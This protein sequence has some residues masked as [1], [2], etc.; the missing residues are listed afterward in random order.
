MEAKAEAKPEVTEKPFYTQTVKVPEHLLKT[1]DTLSKQL[2][3]KAYRLM[4]DRS[5]NTLNFKAVDVAHVSL[6]EVFIPLKLLEGWA[7]EQG[8]VLYISEDSMGDVL[9]L[10]G[11]GKTLLFHATRPENSKTMVNTKVSAANFN[12]S[13][14]HYSN[15]EEPTTPKVPKLTFP[16]EFSIATATLQKA[17]KFLL[18]TSDHMSFIAENN[19]VRLSTI[20]KKKTVEGEFFLGTVTM[21]K[22]FTTI[23]SAYPGN[24]L[25]DVVQSFDPAIFSSV[26]IGINNDLPMQVVG[27]SQDGIVLRRLLAPRIVDD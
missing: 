10:P 6:A 1:L 18:K 5:T 27:V 24:Y 13:V 4:V 19:L 21:P 22:E 9:K 23:K 7:M 14:T 16:M 25:L 8:D 11:A 15:F 12:G 26:T 20:R 3:Q 17:V 2:Q